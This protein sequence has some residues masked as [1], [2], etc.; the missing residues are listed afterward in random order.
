MLDP[1]IWKLMAISLRE[2]GW[3]DDLNMRIG[4]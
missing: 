3:V 2:G 4:G 1:T